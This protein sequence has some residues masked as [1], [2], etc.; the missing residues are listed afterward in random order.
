MRD[1][2]EEDRRLVSFL[3]QITEYTLSLAEKEVKQ[4]RGMGIYYDGSRFEVYEGVTLSGYDE[5]VI[6]VY[7][8]KG[9]A[10][11]VALRPGV[12]SLTAS[13]LSGEGKKLSFTVRVT[14]KA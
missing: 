10:D 14:V 7:G 5:S 8:E 12:T 9:G 4:I 13:C 6:R 2:S 3:P 11:F 1:R